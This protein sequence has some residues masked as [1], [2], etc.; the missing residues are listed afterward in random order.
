[1]INKKQSKNEKLKKQKF[2]NFPFKGIYTALATPF[3]RADE[4]KID[5]DALEKIIKAQL[6]A[7]IDGL[8]LFGSTGEHFSLTETEKKD[9]F[10]TVKE[11]CENKLPLLCCAGNP[12]TKKT[13]TDALLF[14][15]YGANGLLLLPPFYYKCA[16]NGVIAHFLTIAE[17]VKLPTIIYNVPARTGFDLYKKPNVLNALSSMNYVAGIKQAESDELVM[18]D[19][20]KHSI[21]P[22]LSGCDENNFAAYKA[23]AA[24]SISVASNVFPEKIK[25][26]YDLFFGGD[27]SA[28]SKKENSLKPLYKALTLESN[29][30]PLKYALKTVFNASENLRLPLTALSEKHKKQ[31]DKILMKL[32][33]KK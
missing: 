32:L 2:D 11:L 14:K 30:I 33:N 22:V 16:D 12:S 25:E 17:N 5:Y 6:S 27:I 13:L 21:L 10:F 31:A 7:K 24:G 1:M 9:V 26:V 23:G 3:S 29:P 28:A 15:S 18:S 20:I 4:N 8:V 19:F